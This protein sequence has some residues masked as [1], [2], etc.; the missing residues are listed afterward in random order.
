MFPYITH[1]GETNP[2]CGEGLTKADLA[3]RLCSARVDKALPKEVRSSE[4]FV[5]VRAR[6]DQDWTTHTAAIYPDSPP[7]S[8]VVNARTNPKWHKANME[9]EVHGRLD[10]W[11]SVLRLRV[12]LTVGYPTTAILPTAPTLQPTLAPTA[13][14]TAVPTAPTATPTAAPSAPGATS[15]PSMPP[16]SKPSLAPT[17][18]PTADPTATA[19]ATPTA[20][21]TKQPVKSNVYKY[22]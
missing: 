22:V 9:H 11:S 13:T 8:H 2:G 10:H 18:T 1:A 5:A 3:T 19:T 16:T 4:W 17:P 14:P 20:I 12:H 15:A 6:V 7:Q 21:P